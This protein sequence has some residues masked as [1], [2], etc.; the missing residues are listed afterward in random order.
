M[1]TNTD[2][3][4]ATTD[5]RPAPVG[6]ELESVTKRF[7]GGVT[8][9]RDVTMTIDP[10]EFVVLVGPSGC[11]KSTL[12]RIV[13][14]LEEVTGGRVGIGGDDVTTR[15]P[16]ERDVAMVFQSYALYPRMSVRRNL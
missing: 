10:G 6:V 2:T 3:A 5:R 12:L 8:A 14:G 1:D 4:A 16:Q 11:G 9:I 15:L 7:R 13:A